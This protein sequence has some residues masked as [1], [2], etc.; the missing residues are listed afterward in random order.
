VPKRVLRYAAEKVQKAV[1]HAVVSPGRFTRRGWNI[2][3][4]HYPLQEAAGHEAFAIRPLQVPGPYCHHASLLEFAKRFERC[5]KFL[6]GLC[7]VPGSF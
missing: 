2:P 6:G 7:H 5:G 4:L 1:Y 3:T